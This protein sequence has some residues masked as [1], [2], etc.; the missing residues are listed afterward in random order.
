M[1]KKR[2]GFTLIELMIVIAII[3]ILAAILV[4]NFLRARAQGNV[5]ACKSN[6]KNMGTAQEMYA[7]DN[8]GLYAATLASLTTPI[9]Y[10]QTLPTCPSSGAYDLSTVAGNTAYTVYCSGT[11]H[12]GVGG[13]TSANQP[14]FDS[15]QGLLPK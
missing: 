5:T 13:V 11:V 2:K 4:P 7:T 6:V 15:S 1:R 12:S 9:S 10:L 3:A 8:S 14:S